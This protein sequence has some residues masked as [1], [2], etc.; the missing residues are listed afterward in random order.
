MDQE[1]K[2]S[3]NLDPNTVEGDD[4]KELV[5]QRPPDDAAKEKL[6]PWLIRNAPY[7]IVVL[8][9][10]LW[11]CISQEF[12][13]EKVFALVK[14]AL[15]LGLVIFVHEL[16]H[17]LVAKWC[18]VHV[19]TFSIGFGPPIPGCMFRRGETTYMIALFP[20]GGY[21]KMVG[22]GPE[23]EHEDDPRSFKNKPVWQRM[24]IISAGV[25]M[26]LLLAFVCFA[27]VFRTHGAER[28]PG[29][30]DRIVPGSPAWKVGMRSGDVIYMLGNKGPRPYFNEIQPTIVHSEKELKL[31]FGPPNLPEK[32]WVTT[33]IMARRGEDNSR[34]MIGISPPQELT[35]LPPKLRKVHE[36]PVRYHSAAAGAN[37][38]FEFG[39]SI[40]GTTDPDQ[41]EDLNRI[42]PLKPD[43]RLTPEDPNH[44]DYFEFERRLHRLAGKKMVLEVRRQKSGEIVKIRVPA[45]YYFTLGLRLPMGKIVAIRDNSSAAKAGLKSDDIIEKVEMTGPDGRKIRYPEDIKDPL[46]LSYEMESWASRAASPKLVTLMV[47]Q[48]NPLAS[49]QGPGNFPERKPVIRTLPWEDGWEFNKESP[50]N[51]TIP[52]LGIAF[53]IETTILQVEPNS[54]AT[55]AV[56]ENAS[57]ITCDE[58]DVIER[59]DGSKLTAQKGESLEL[60]EGDQIPLKKGDVIKAIQVLKAG[61]KSSDEG[62]PQ[63]WLE[64]KNDRWAVA[65]ETIQ[66]LEIKKFKLRL[67]RGTA[68]LEVSLTAIEDA[69]WP[70]DDRGI[71]LEPDL[72]LQKADSLVKAAGMGISETV[73]FTYQIFEN[74][75]AIPSVDEVAGPLRIADFAFQIAGEDSYKFL[76]FLG[77]ICV[78]LAVINFLPIPVLDGGHMAFLIYEWIRGKPAPEAV[79][80]AATYVGLALIASLMIFVLYLDVKWLL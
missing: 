71:L 72:R 51:I 1:F 78:N 43:P 65:F 44:L 30:V 62:K 54:A 36:L 5:D 14:V 11:F 24:A 19:E 25:T 37:P 12:D 77:I 29:V 32:D 45:A 7:L 61:K 66:E 76:L 16:G 63:K 49:Q 46:R 48:A 57:S 3:K 74:L 26:N 70:R 39:D 42:M 6:G 22:E 28:P 55:H 68:S 53:R 27:F 38:P 18:D 31:V 8:A 60:K 47:S 21:V 13:P 59:K 56:V 40:I 41:A 9:L 20:L 2:P 67:E 52:G 75:L 34:R 35:L 73:T 17:F 33:A 4:R 79:R 58:G 10:F 69:T 23:E 64:I 50:P 15:G 80:V